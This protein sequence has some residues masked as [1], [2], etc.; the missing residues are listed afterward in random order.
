MQK[1][2]IKMY[3]KGIGY[4]VVSWFRIQSSEE[5]LGT[6]KRTKLNESGKFFTN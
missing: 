6:Q 3:H 2:N 1:G 5:L 4:K